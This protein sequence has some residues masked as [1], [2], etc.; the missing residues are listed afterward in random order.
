MSD[1]SNPF[2]TLGRP[3]LASVQSTAPEVDANNNHLTVEM[4]AIMDTD[5][6]ALLRNTAES[7]LSRQ[8]KY[9]LGSAEEIRSMLDLV[10]K[11]MENDQRFDAFDLA[12]VFNYVRAVMVTLRVNPE[13][14]SIL[15][16]DDVH[17]LC[18]YT[19]K[20][21]QESANQ[22]GMAVAASERRAK[23]VT[24]SAVKKGISAKDMEAAA[25]AMDAILGGFKL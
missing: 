4:L 9:T 6:I 15:L 10:K 3:N 8:S 5:E 25:A 23:K 12:R 17:A 18:A 13:Y 19:Q 20:Q 21:F 24:T 2:T 7:M 16:D 14:E 22:E 11:E 1:E